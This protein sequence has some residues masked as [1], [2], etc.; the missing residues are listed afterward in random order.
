MAQKVALPD[1]TWAWTDK[2]GVITHPLMGLLGTLK[3]LFNQ[4]GVC[5]DSLGWARSFVALLALNPSCCGMSGSEEQRSRKSLMLPNSLLSSAHF[6]CS[7][8]E[9]LSFLL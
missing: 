4:T 6:N 5:A 1:A 9:T 2:P 8:L 7:R 3:I